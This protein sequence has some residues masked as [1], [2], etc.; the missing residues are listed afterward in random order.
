MPGIDTGAPDRTATSSGRR[1]TAEGAARRGF[2][3]REPVRYDLGQ[4]IRQA[5]ATLEILAAERRTQHEGGRHGQTEPRQTEEAIRLGAQGLD[6]R[7]SRRW[8]PGQHEMEM[9]V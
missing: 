1:G 6:A 4:I 8:H 9:L 3:A 5:A 7:L 2:E